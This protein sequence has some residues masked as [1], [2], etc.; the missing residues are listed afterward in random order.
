[1][2]IK[3]LLFPLAIAS[4]IFS[5]SCR[6]TEADYVQPVCKYPVTQ[7]QH[8]YGAETFD[9]LWGFYDLDAWKSCVIRYNGAAFTDLCTAE[10]GGVK[11]RVRGNF[12]DVKAYMKLTDNDSIEVPMKV[13]TLDSNLKSF[14]GEVNNIDYVPYYQHYPARMKPVLY[15]RMPYDSPYKDYYYMIGRLKINLLSVEIDPT[16]KSI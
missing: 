2:K 14:D 4:V 5:S 7:F 8:V 15:I 1:M 11:V 13:T 3:S 9:K 10:K 16:G 6:R 12:I